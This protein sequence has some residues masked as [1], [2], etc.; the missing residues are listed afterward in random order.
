MADLE[1][2]AGNSLPVLQAWCKDHRTSAMVQQGRVV[3]SQTYYI[4]GSDHQIFQNVAVRDL[5]HNSD[6]LMALGCLHR[7]SPREN[8][9]Y[10][11]RRTRLPLHPPGRQMRTRVERSLLSCGTPSQSRT[12]GWRATTCGYRRRRGDLSTRESPQGGNQV[13]T[14]G[15]SD[16]WAV[17]FGRH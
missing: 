6:H 8:L 10:L 11:R 4:L 7:T 17:P 13:E 5:S 12:N 2:L 15:D 16:G 14:S 1:D 9:H 3:R